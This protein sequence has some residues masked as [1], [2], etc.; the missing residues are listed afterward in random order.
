MSNQFDSDEYIVGQKPRFLGTFRL[1][2][3]L[4]DPTVV[5]FIYQSPSAANPTVLTYGVD[6]ALE[7]D[8]VGLYHVDL[9][10]TEAGTWRWRYESTGTV[11]SAQQGYLR[12]KAEVPVG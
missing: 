8:S 9:S 10:L 2:K 12:V 4:T 1:G 3:V 7:R 11:E 6:A 5:K